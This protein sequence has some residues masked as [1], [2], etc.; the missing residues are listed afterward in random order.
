[1]HVYTFIFYV[2]TQSFVKNGYFLC[3]IQKDKKLCREKAYFYQI[4]SFIYR[5]YKKSNFVETTL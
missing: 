5:P 3:P 1:M 4:L 2:V